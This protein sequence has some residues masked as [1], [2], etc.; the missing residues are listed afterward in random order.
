MRIPIQSSFIL[1]VFISLL[2]CRSVIYEKSDD[3]IL[4]HTNNPDVK[5][6]KLQVI[7]EDIIHISAT[8][9]VVFPDFES[10]MVRKTKKP[11]KAWKS[12]IRKDTVFVKTVDLTVEVIRNT[13]EIRFK[14]KNGIVK[15]QELPG[16]GKSFEPVT[17][18]GRN[19][20]SVRQVFKSPDDEAFFGLGQHQNRQMNYK[21][22]DVELAQHNIVAVVPFIYSSKN[23]GILWDNYSITRFGD[24]REYQ[25]LSSLQLFDKN[26]KPGGLT[27]A[28]YR[29]YE[30]LF[31]RKEDTIDF[32]YIESAQRWPDSLNANNVTKIIWEGFFSS[33]VRGNHKFRLYAS[34]YFRLWIDGKPIF[35]KWRQNW[36]PWYNRFTVDVTGEE[37]H[38]IK[39]EWVPNGGY[40]SMDHLDPLPIE[41]QQKLSLFSEAALVLDYYYI[42]GNSADEVISG[43][44]KLTGKAPVMP[45]WAMGF[46]Q[47]RER[48]KTQ[49]ELLGIVEEYRRRAIPLDNIVQDWFY[50]EE[51]K[52][53]SHRFDTKR[54]PDAAGMIKELHQDLH[55][56]IMISVWPKFYPGTDNFNALDS[57]GFLYRYMLEKGW[58]DWVGPGYAS[59]FYDA[60]NPDGR[61]LFWEQIDKNLN[62][63]GIDAWWL[64]ATEPD[65]QSNHSIGVRKRMMDSTY[66][67]PGAQFFNGYSLMNSKGVYEGSRK[68]E[69]DKRV[70]ILTRSAFGGQQKYAAA[71][72]SGDVASR[73]SD[74][75]DQIAAG[76]NFCISGIPYW[77]HDIGGFSLENRYINPASQD[78]EE[79]REL[80][81]R[82]FQFGAFSPLF[83]SHGKYP[84][85]EIFNIA[86][87]THNAYKSMVYYDKLRYRLMPYIYSLA[88][89]TFLNDYTIMRALIMDFPADRN[90]YGIP[91]EFMFG[92]S[93]L[94]SPVYEF[95]ARSRKI[96]FPAGYGWYD[97]YTGKYT[98]GGKAI[99]APA[100]YNRIPV[101]AREG[102]ILLLGPD[103]Q[104]TDQKPADTITLI[105][106]AGKNGDFTLYEDDGV[107]Y[108]YE[109]GE[110]TQIRIS[111]DEENNRV[112]VGDRQGSYPGMIGKRSFRV[113]RVSPEKPLGIDDKTPDFTLID[114]NGKEISTEL[115]IE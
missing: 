85:R 31:S 65:M 91:D 76:L 46:W 98:E 81:T 42:N 41:E 60:F 69:P 45:K 109:K 14:D 62:S 103:I 79:W 28:Y 49:D 68:R 77:T 92:P 20:F 73:W 19:L 90:V 110:Y 47:S 37:R 107:S 100:P 59:T 16:G 89:V 39:L 75:G 72:W 58:K 2:S 106:Y 12:F 84:Y 27:A 56:K 7:N 82:W 51:D 21:G 101:Y 86:P 70:F 111:Y 26:N 102:S 18:D 105:V 97:I 33:P 52:W 48:Y 61:T 23:Y 25:P 30:L 11:F 74:L 96:Y 5:L 78:L 108:G 35:D 15:L 71:T 83:R 66:L 29:N 94:V 63:K 8:P 38:T 95:K 17:I 32:Q 93:L 53:G 55:A 3:A 9:Y 113:L 64:D 57:N 44:R 112:T 34:E 13:G 88:G 80:N 22:E 99:E 67:G 36:N 10:L 104:Y 6:I 40:L 1:L 4:I 43:Y 24:P 114:Y 50:W 54:F 87:E 115:S